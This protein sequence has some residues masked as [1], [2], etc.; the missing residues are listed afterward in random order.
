MSIY[1][2]LNK[3]IVYNLSFVNVLMMLGNKVL[4]CCIKVPNYS[5]KILN[6]SNKRSFLFP[7]LKEPKGSKSSTNKGLVMSG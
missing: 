4:N 3:Y 6:N 7:Y 1:L 2:Y 5:Y